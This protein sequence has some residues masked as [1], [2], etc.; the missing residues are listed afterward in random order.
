MKKLKN[1][2]INIKFLN[3]TFNSK[4]FCKIYTLII[5]IRIKKVML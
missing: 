5:I 1:L 3:I 2:N 4:T